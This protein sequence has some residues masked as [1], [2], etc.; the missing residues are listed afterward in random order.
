M[1]AAKLDD[2]RMLLGLTDDV[3]ELLREGQS[4]PFSL[5]D[6]GGTDSIVMVYA[7]TQQDIVNHLR[8]GAAQMGVELPDA[9]PTIT[10]ESEEWHP[11]TEVH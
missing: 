10:I 2:G 7:P 1:I 3:I 11:P 6:C 9:P 8:A 5:S 4:L